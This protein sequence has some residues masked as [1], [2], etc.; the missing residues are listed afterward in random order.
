MSF[1][2]ESFPAVDPLSIQWSSD[3]AYV[4]KYVDGKVQK[5][6]VDIV[7]RNTDGVLVRGDIALGDQ[8]VTQGV[9]QLSEGASV[10]L[11][12]DDGPQGQSGQ[13]EQGQG[14]AREGGARNG[15]GGGTAGASSAPA[16]S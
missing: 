13:R 1:P 3:G 5:A 8:V 6:M 12:G 4:W 11:L 2:G 16:A 7:Q 15:Q 14:Q 9:L 10:R